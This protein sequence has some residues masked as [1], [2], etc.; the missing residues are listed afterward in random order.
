[1]QVQG[2]VNGCT[3]VHV[4]L[5]S[6]QVSITKGRLFQESVYGYVCLMFIDDALRQVVCVCVILTVCDTIG[7]VVCVL[8]SRWRYSRAGCSCSQDKAAHNLA[9]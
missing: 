8:Y 2:Q 6:L 9:D 1:M 5:E 7:Q 4:Y 3:S